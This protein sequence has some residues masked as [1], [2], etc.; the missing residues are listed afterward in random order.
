MVLSVF[1]VFIAIVLVASH[2]RRLATIGFLAIAP[3]LPI[4]NFLFA[5]EVHLR[6]NGGIVASNLVFGAAIR[7]LFNR[8]I[9]CLAG[10]PAIKL[11][12][13]SLVLCAA[14]CLLLCAPIPLPI[15][16]TR[17]AIERNNRCRRDVGATQPPCRA[18]KVLL[19][20]GPMRFPLWAHVITVE[21][22]AP[23]VCGLATII[24]LGLIPRILPSVPLLVAIVGHIR[25][26]WASQTVFLAARGFFFF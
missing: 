11:L 25:G 13:S 9:I 2:I 10:L 3:S 1:D 14:P 20:L 21:G 22:V 23:S 26:A 19:V 6:H 16:E 8:P 17:I 7:A 24:L 12:A 5:I 4:I 18:A 15:V